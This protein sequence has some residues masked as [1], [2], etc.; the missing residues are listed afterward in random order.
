MNITKLNERE[1]W[2]IQLLKKEEARLYR[3]VKLTDFG[4]SFTLKKVKFVE[5][6]EGRAPPPLNPPLVNDSN[7]TKY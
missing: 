6:R 2:R 7:Y 5:K 1:Q 4:L 3:I